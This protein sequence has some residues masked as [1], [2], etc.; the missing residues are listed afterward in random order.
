MIR[1]AVSALVQVKAREMLYMVAQTFCC[2]Y[3]RNL[4]HPPTI[5]VLLS[6]DLPSHPQGTHPNYP[7]L[8]LLLFSYFRTNKII[9][10]E[11]IVSNILK[12]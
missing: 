11:T 9:I 10:G 8:H 7:V 3:E 4:N 1:A 2:L 6:A 12:D 5:L